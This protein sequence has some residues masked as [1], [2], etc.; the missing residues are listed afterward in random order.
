MEQE[1]KTSVWKTLSILIVFPILYMLFGE[2]YIAKELFA[3]KNLDYYIPFWGG[4]IILHWTSV[5]VIMRFLKS[6]GK[7]LADIGYKLSRKGTL[8][9][10]GGYFL[11]AFLLV[12]GIE[13]MLSNVELDNSRFGNLSGLIPKTTPHRLFF[14]FLVLSTGLCEEIVYRG[15]AINQLEKIGLNKWLALII[16]ALIFIGIHGINAY[17]GSFIFYFGGGI[18][19][20]LVFLFSKRLLP[21]IILHLAINLSAMMAILELMR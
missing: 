4:I 12:V 3:N 16:A 18:M 1:K 14:L 15:F 8:L 7:T 6:E 19:F 9:L 2:T 10:V 17:S 11:I 5:F 20:G 21:S 13:V